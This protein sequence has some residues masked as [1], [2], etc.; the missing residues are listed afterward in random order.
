MSR[1]NIL[2][3]PQDDLIPHAPRTGGLNA[4]KERFMMGAGNQLGQSIT[5]RLGE[6]Q[7]LLKR[8]ASNWEGE[9]VTLAFQ[10]DTDD[11][12]VDQAPALVVGRVRFGVGGAQMAFDFSMKRGSLMTLPATSIEIL[13]NYQQWLNSPIIALAPPINV[14]V[15]AAYGCK[16]GLGAR[17][18][19]TFDYLR[20]TIAAG[21]FQD[22]PIPRFADV[23]TLYAGTPGAFTTGAGT[24]ISF[25][26]VAGVPPVVS[27][28]ET[29]VLGQFYPPDLIP[30][31]S[32]VSTCRITN[33]SP[34][35]QTYSLQFG[36]PF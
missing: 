2:I 19:I 27:I 32:G 30:I 24:S 17:P 26:S 29:L 18:T 21:A 13:A 5:L 22:F 31:P 16:P 15:A 7:T 23:L 8:D 1:R 33:G 36:L 25:R 20:Q 4:P 6:T 35:P 10:V 12:P 34:N 9:L 28:V 3:A 14:R 11:N